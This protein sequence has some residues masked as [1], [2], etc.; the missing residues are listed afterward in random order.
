MLSIQRNFKSQ[1]CK[2]SMVYSVKT[3]TDEARRRRGQL[4]PTIRVEK[5]EQGR[6]IYC[7]LARRHRQTVGVRPLRATNQ[8][9]RDLV[10]QKTDVC[11]VGYRKSMMSSH[12]EQS[13][14]MK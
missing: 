10:K 9:E 13:K 4:L 11:R 8:P 7:R 12:T 2:D 14:P 6:S 1:K 5:R 3:S